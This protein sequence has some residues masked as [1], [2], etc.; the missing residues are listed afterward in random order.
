MQDLV[1]IPLTISTGV[2]LTLDKG[3]IQLLGHLLPRI[4]FWYQLD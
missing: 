4:V 2:L 3:V 1:I